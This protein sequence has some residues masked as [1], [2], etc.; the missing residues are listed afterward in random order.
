MLR[1]L[2]LSRQEIQPSPPGDRLQVR[3]NAAGLNVRLGA[4]PDQGHQGTRAPRATRH[5]GVNPDAEIDW[6]F[7]GVANRHDEHIGFGCRLHRARIGLGIRQVAN[8]P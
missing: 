8:L 6:Q 3:V 4:H 5:P 2:A 1:Q 7:S